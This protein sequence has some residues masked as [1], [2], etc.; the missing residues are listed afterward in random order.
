MCVDVKCMITLEHMAELPSSGEG[1]G[2]GGSL[3]VGGW[4][5]WLVLCDAHTRCAIVTNMVEN[6]CIPMDFKSVLID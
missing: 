3:E 1:R 5:G 2:G 4:L 6:Y